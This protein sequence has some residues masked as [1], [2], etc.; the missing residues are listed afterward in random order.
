VVRGEKRMKRM[1]SETDAKKAREEIGPE[2]RY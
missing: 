2:K 1:I